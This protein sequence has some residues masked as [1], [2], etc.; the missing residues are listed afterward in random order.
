MRTLKGETQTPPPPRNPSRRRRGI[1]GELPWT[2][3]AG[4]NCGRRGDSLDAS[5]ACAVTFLAAHHARCR[6]NYRG[7]AWELVRGSPLA[8]APP[9]WSGKRKRG[10]GEEGDWVESDFDQC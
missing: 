8:G 10:G 1:A 2:S 6:S 9:S 3:I 4:R 7:N 5:P